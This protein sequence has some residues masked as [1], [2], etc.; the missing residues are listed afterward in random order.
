MNR[1]DVQGPLAV[2]EKDDTRVGSET[3]R[4]EHAVGFEAC[5]DA[6][7]RR[8]RRLKVLARRLD[9]RVGLDVPQE[10]A[11]PRMGRLPL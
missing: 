5:R 11:V 2:V 8:D 6:V 4:L 9:I 1:L 10:D 3:V 7:E